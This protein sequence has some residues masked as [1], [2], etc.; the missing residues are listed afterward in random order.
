MVN[1][2]P[3]LCAICHI[4]VRFQ[5]HLCP[6]HVDEFKDQLVYDSNKRTWKV[7]P[8]TAPWLYA[9]I[10]YDNYAYNVELRDVGKVQPLDRVSGRI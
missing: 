8:L 6:S 10:Q 5:D 4:K 2:P 9:I 3:R 7:G 1:Y